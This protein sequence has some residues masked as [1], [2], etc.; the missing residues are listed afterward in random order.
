[1][2]MFDYLLSNQYYFKPLRRNLM[3]IA[4]V[5]GLKTARV[6]AGF[7]EVKASYLATAFETINWQYGS[8]DQYARQGLDLTQEQ[9]EYLRK[10]YLQ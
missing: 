7:L 8:F 10:L 9:I 4:I 5:K 1:M 6:V 3:M 2:V